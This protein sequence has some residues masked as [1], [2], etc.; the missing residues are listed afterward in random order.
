MRSAACWLEAGDKR[1]G[2][3]ADGDVDQHG[4]D[5][6]IKRVVAH[7]IRYQVGCLLRY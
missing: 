2:I 5:H 6:S 1:C 7:F 4:I 3:G